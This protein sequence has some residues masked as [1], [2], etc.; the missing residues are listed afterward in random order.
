MRFET[1]RRV[2]ADTARARFSAFL[3]ERPT[4]RRVRGSASS[5]NV[6]SMAI[7]SARSCFSIPSAPARANSRRRS[8]L[9]FIDGLATSPPKTVGRILPK[10][11]GKFW[12]RL[13]TVHLPCSPKKES[14]NVHRTVS[15]HPARADPRFRIKRE[16]CY[17]RRGLPGHRHHSRWQRPQRGRGQPADQPHLYRQQWRRY[18]LRD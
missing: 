1:A 16:L 5:G 8:V 9:N 3:I 12:G 14:S 15:V 13:P 7:I 2:A 17:T 18:D 11:I 4:A 6:R 10:A